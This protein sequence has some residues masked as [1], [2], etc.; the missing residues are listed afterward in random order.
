M[1]DDPIKLTW[2]AFLEFCRCLTGHATYFFNAR[3]DTSPALT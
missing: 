3:L 1:D 2:I